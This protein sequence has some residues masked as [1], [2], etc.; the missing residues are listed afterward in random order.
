[1]H[2]EIL[3]HLAYSPDLAPSDF[4]LFG[5]FKEALRRKGFRGDNEVKFSYDN[6]WRSNRKLFLKGA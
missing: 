4:P 5:A 1:M 2:W 3:P 6:G